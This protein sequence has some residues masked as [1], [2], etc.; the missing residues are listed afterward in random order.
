MKTKPA[1]R[2][3]AFIEYKGLN[4]RQFLLACNLSET[5]IDSIS[6][7]GGIGPKAQ[8]HISY[9][10][11]DINIAWLITGQGE[12][13]LTGEPLPENTTPLAVEDFNLPAKKSLAEIDLPKEAFRQLLAEK[14]ML[15][16]QLITD[17]RNLYELL[18]RL[19]SKK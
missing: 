9:A 8:K 4:R 3:L 7:G 17:K 19:T 5:Y 1:E 15:I 6:N 10:F 18:N 13:L 14:D 12:M 2:L 16:Q 11:P